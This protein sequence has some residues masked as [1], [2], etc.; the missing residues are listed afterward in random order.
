MADLTKV[1]RDQNLTTVSVRSSDW[2]P[3]FV[4]T[5]RVVSAEDLGKI[6]VRADKA[7]QKILLRDVARI[8]QVMGWPTLTAVD[9][10]PAA[11][12][13]IS[14]THDANPKDTDKAVRQWLAEMRKQFPVGI[15]AKVIGE[16]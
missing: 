6:V 8:E 1:L 12:L 16:P 9:G 3:T 15:E 13:L 5:G 2:M 11:V 14:R 4:L 10:K 7:G